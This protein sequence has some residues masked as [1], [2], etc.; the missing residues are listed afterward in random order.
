MIYTEEDTF[1]TL[2]LTPYMSIIEN[3]NHSFTRTKTDWF[4]L[5]KKSAQT[6]CETHPDKYDNQ[7]QYAFFNKDNPPLL[8]LFN[9]ILEADWT[10]EE[11]YEE[12]LRRSK[13]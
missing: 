3:I 13:V 9:I 11:F 10:L 2:R 6:T 4:A 7:L 5:L 8:L 1:N 12:T